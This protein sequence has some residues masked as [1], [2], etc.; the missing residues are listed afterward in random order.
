V[1]PDKIFVTVDQRQMNSWDFFFADQHELPQ[2]VRFTVLV[3]ADTDLRCWTCTLFTIDA[4]FTRCAS[5]TIGSKEILLMW[6]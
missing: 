5:D 6:L 3:T 4:K 1:F 2:T